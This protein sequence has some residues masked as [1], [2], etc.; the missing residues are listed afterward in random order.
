MALR[1]A[2]LRSA[3]R[4]LKMTLR[5]AKRHLQHALAR[6]ISC[7]SKT[8]LRHLVD[9]F[10]QTWYR[11]VST[12]PLVSKVYEKVIYEQTSNYFEPFFNEIL[13]GFQE[14]HSIK[15]TLFKLLAS[16]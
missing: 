10:L 5:S 2:I 3:K 7:L 11:P 8:S 12:L 14:A 9:V 1:F 15:Q 13:C 4:H 16:W 6:C